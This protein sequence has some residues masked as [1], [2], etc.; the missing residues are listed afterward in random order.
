M[1]EIENQKVLT[2]VRIT[3]Y[4]QFMDLIAIVDAESTGTNQIVIFTLKDV[5]A[6]VFHTISLVFSKV[7]QISKETE[8]ISVANMVTKELPQ[9]KLISLVAPNDL[10]IVSSEA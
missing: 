10:K 7:P 8:A 5:E 2:N 1:L 4:S 9:G 6:K 3:E